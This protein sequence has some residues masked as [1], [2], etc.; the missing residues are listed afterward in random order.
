VSIA[1]GVYHVGTALLI[2][3]IAFNRWAM[4]RAVLDRGLARIG[5]AAGAIPLAGVL[6]FVVASGMMYTAGYFIGADSMVGDV[7]Q[8]VYGRI[9]SA[10]V[11]FI[12]NVLGTAALG[13]YMVGLGR[14]LADVPAQRARAS[15]AA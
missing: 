13:A 11:P 4:R 7:S 2:M 12:C 9:L 3:L 5:V 14:L 15:T 8:W 10:P 1:L 6:W